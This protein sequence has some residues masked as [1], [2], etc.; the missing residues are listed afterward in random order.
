[1]SKVCGSNQKRE[2]RTYEVGE[3]QQVMVRRVPGFVRSLA[4]CAVLS[5][6]SRAGG[7]EDA[8]RAAAGLAHLQLFAIRGIG[9]AGSMSDGERDLR[10]VLNQPDAAAVLHEIL[11]R[12]TPAGQLYALLG[13]RLRDRAAYERALAALGKRSDVISTARG[14]ILMKEEMAGI[15]REI[16]RGDYDVAMARPPW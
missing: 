5:L 12:A 16:E 15:I 14:C 4:A 6:I 3:H 8:A 10:T 11:P 13:L 7:E 9:V 2:V 1:M